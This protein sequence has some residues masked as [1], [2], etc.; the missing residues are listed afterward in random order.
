M[1]KYWQ[2][3]IFFLFVISNSLF[4][5]IKPQRKG[6]MYL[7]SEQGLSTDLVNCLFEDSRGG[8]WV[9]TNAGLNFY[10]GYRFKV[11][12][13]E[14]NNPNSLS[15]DKITC[16]V[17][18][19]Q[20]QLWV[21]TDK[22]L[23][24]LDL[25]THKIR[26]VKIMNLLNQG[27]YRLLID[28]KSNL[29]V[30]SNRKML[31]LSTHT[32][33]WEFFE[34]ISEIM[35]QMVEFKNTSIF[36]Y[37]NKQGQ[38]ILFISNPFEYIWYNHTTKEKVRKTFKKEHSKQFL[39][40]YK[41]VPIAF[42]QALLNKNPIVDSLLR[43]KNW[44]K[45]ELD[46]L[47]Y[48]K[49]DLWLV[50]RGGLIQYNLTTQQVKHIYQLDK[51]PEINKGL[52]D[53]LLDRSGT[54]WL[55]GIGITVVPTLAIGEFQLIQEKKPPTDFGLNG[56]SV[57]A[58]FQDN[59]QRIWVSAYTQPEYIGIQL[60]DPKNNKQQFIFT[61]NF[62]LQFKLDKTEPDKYVWVAGE[63]H[64]QKINLQTL[65]IIPHKIADWG[66]FWKIVPVKA[67]EMWCIAHPQ[68][69]NFTQKL[70]QYNPIT[71]KVESFGFNYSL[72]SL[73][74]DKQWRVWVGA[75]NGDFYK[76]DKQK[77][78]F[79]FIKNIEKLTI[80][81]IFVDKQQNI[82]LATLGA[83]LWKY[84]PT[85]KQFENFREKD[86]LPSNTVFSIIEDHQDNLWLGT[87]RGLSKFNPQS[88][89]FLNFHTEDGLQHNEF[90]TNATYFNP[91]T[92]TMIFGGIG[93]INIFKPTDFQK[94]QYSPSLVLNEIEKLGKSIALT[95]QGLE[96]QHNH[97]INWS[98][99]VAEAQMLTFRFSALSYYQSWRNE[100]AY[101]IEELNQDW[102]QLGTQNAI[103]LT[104]LPAGNYTIRIK[105]SNHHGEWSKQD[106]VIHLII[107]PPFWQTWW[108]IGLCVLGLISLISLYFYQRWLAI[109]KRNQWLQQEVNKRTSELKEAN[110]EIVSQN[111]ALDK[112]N[113]VK[114][115][116]FA[117]IA[118]DL[119]SPIASFQG[120]S[121]QIH[122][123][124]EKNKPERVHQLREFIA[125]SA[126]N[127]HRLLDNLLS[128]AVIQRNSYSLNQQLL[129]L[130]DLIEET[131]TPYQTMADLHQ[132]QL[133]NLAPS[134]CQIYSDKN[135]LSSI[136]RNLISNALKF[137][138][139]GGKISVDVSLNPSEN[140]ICIQVS[141]TGMG[142]LPEK[143]TT[144]F[145]LGADKTLPGIR[146]EKG[147][148]LGLS[149]C[150][151][152]AQM[153][154]GELKVESQ[155]GRGTIFTLILAQ[156][157]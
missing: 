76:F 58:V 26:R 121:E 155:V 77:K 44:Q 111:D 78:Q 94:N 54:L 20:Q 152:F 62:P 88:K 102:I 59:Q 45:K 132:I 81:D 7:S 149:L 142:I 105:G 40:K 53:I 69:G 108:F 49:G 1:Q 91:K 140:Q 95:N 74:V 14:A 130:K 42:W 41:R 143:M 23:C 57:R 47:D 112:M 34:T 93:G 3:I 12:N 116:L 103:T 51:I 56:S 38:L 28:N 52:S 63:R 83:G 16:F 127:L 144:I 67:D 141:D 70:L 43:Y 126:Q 110:E 29:W 96:F 60:L 117:I 18:D 87:L 86:G 66:Y 72:E 31:R 2:F 125:K 79:Y 17:E 114:D 37:K 138:P 71:H 5:Q 73:D 99:P 25:R 146:G 153:L 27:V 82:W 55:G 61:D 22:G 104:N 106:L 113:R 136:L 129:E 13:Y 100:Y 32:Q 80:K 133:E 6:Y 10:D 145:E 30:A 21:G 8:I 4:A 148:G 150:Y 68:G 50:N 98:L 92:N 151:E 75:A 109:K 119:R 118:H 115:R 39:M 120:I 33:Q 101:K 64:P 65:E 15:N 122:Y 97:Q 84:N 11:F 107:Q 139:E 137:T 19:H 154:E 24:V 157:P 124:L 46:V 135:A 85:T 90:N 35:R 9:G 134:N 156:K 36:E 128:W 147:I 48:S 131:L 89:A 123:F